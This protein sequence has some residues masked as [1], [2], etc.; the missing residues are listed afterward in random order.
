MYTIYDKS[1][2]RPG[3][4]TNGGMLYEN[5]FQFIIEEMD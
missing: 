2:M 5:V 4:L 1:V 3:S